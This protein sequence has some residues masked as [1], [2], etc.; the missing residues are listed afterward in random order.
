MGGQQ[1]PD[2]VPLGPDSILG[3]IVTDPRIGLTGFSTGL[4]QVMH[5]AVS[6]GVIQH[7]EFFDDPFDRVYRSVP[8]I[9]ATITGDDGADRA[10]TVR[11]YHRNIKGTDANGARYHALDPEVYWWT[12]MCFVWGFLMTA[13]RFRHGRLTPAER[14]QF[15]AESVEWWR[16][17][18][19]SMRY[20]PPDLDSFLEDFEQRCATDLEWTEAAAGALEVTTFQAPFPAPL[21]RLIGIPLTPVMRLAMI[22]TLPAD[23][24][25]RFGLPW[26]RADQLAYVSLAR[27]VSQGGRFLPAY[28]MQQLSTMFLKRLGSRTHLASDAVSA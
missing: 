15:Y 12:H 8:R 22:G 17:Y 7:S 27:A 9:V 2:P 14:A 3:R 23:V 4:L 6:A 5:P 24:R 10:V 18:G 11:D 20:V 19:M 16:R 1:L 26:S 25:E 13:E 28:P 21:D